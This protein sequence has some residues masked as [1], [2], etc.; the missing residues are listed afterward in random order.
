MQDRIG[1]EGPPGAR[2]A[3]RDIDRQD[4]AP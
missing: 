1:Q 3:G 2:T 4:C